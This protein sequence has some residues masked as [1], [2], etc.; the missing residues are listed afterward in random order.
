M[1]LAFAAGILLFQQAAELPGAGVLAGGLLLAVAALRWSLLP[2]AAWAG[3]AWFAWHASDLL[4]TGLPE[5]LDRVDVTVTGTVATLPLRS[6]RATRF[7]FLPDVRQVAVDV[8][9]P[10]R[11]R[12][13]W[14]G[15][16]PPLKAGERWRLRL[17]LKR[18][19]GFANP[20]GFDYE[21]WLFRRG[22]RAT[23]YVRDH[24]ANTGLGTAAGPLAAL[25]RL[26]QRLADRLDEALATSPRR[27]LVAALA[28]GERGAIAQDQWQVLRRTGTSHLVAISGLHL[29]LVAGLMFALARWAWSCSATL[30][31]RG[32]APL[33]AAWATLPAAALYAGLAGLSVPTQRALVMVVVVLTAT[34]LRR[35]LGPGRGLALALASVLLLDPLA[36]GA[37][38]FWLSFGAVAA[39]LYVVAWRQP[40]VARLRRWIGVQLALAV[41]L[42]PLLVAAFQQVPLVAPLANLVAVP[43]VGLVLV[44]LVLLATLLLLP[45][46]TLGGALLAVADRLLEYAWIP[47]EALA[48]WPLAERGFAAPPL[49]LAIVGIVGALLLLVPRGLPLRLP[50]V[51]LLLPMLTYQP[52][53]PAH[54]AAWLT[55]LDV[56][57]GLAAVVRTRN[58]LLVFDT[59]PAYSPRFDAGSAALAPLLHGLGR[60]R[61]D[62]VVVSHGDSDHAGG[63][64][65]L[66]AAVTVDRLLVGPGVTASVAAEPC[67]AGQGWRWDGVEFALLAPTEARA[68]NDG[69]CVLRVEA[70]GGTLL[71]TGDIEADA[72]RTLLATGDD[73]LRATVLQVPHHGSRT[74]STPAFI[75]AVAPRLALVASGWR[76]RFGL[77]DAGVVDRYRAAGA[78]VLDTATAGAVE[79]RLPAV[80]GAPTVSERRQVSRRFWRAR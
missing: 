34:L 68:G 48:D 70:G 80:A 50:G 23:G 28:L 2:L 54:G 32:P 76:N 18:P 5:A 26:R 52:P 79:V 11:L 41:A 55:L 59:G 20:A 44:P 35:A 40:G 38:G 3:V 4:A 69:S 67:R 77:P 24:P 6:G 36:P 1:L 45:L 56:G 15:T 73:A 42:A 75:A 58:H 53:A 71:L 60:R 43:L 62:A 66:L 64:R 30:T 13:A 72:E 33:A 61:V 16:H 19:R 22:I 25:Q 37:A 63:L 46:P 78:M 31:R 47:L 9:L 51:V 7:E 21:G 39:I 57:Q 29:G 17:R 14:Y 10:K 27:G 74:S 12:L 49:G 8:I 65:S